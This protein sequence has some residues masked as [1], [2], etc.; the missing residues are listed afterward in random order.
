MAT[1]K[2]VITDGATLTD[3]GTPASD[4]K[5][6]IQD[7]SDSNTVKYVDWS[8]IGGGGGITDIVQDTTPQLGGNLDLNS[9]NV[10]GTGGIDI[11]GNIITSAGDLRMGTNNKFLQGK[12][13]GGA[14]R[15]IIGANASDQIVIGAAQYSGVTLTGVVTASSGIK[16]ILTSTSSISSAGDYGVGSEVYYYGST[17]T[18][19]G[20]IYYLD[21][22]GWTLADADAESTAK[23]LLGVAIGT[24]SGTNGMVIRGMVSLSVQGSPAVGAQV[25]LST[26]AGGA[27]S[28]APSATGD[29]QRILGH[30][31]GNGI[32]Y[33]NPSSDYLE[34][35]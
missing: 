17:T 35:A 32:V 28:V 5:L 3:I 30:V 7:T 9:S 1:W 20:Q 18:T 2:K 11:T 34:I 31:T 21:G 25:F 16:Q 14:T 8:D 29:I 33:F 24:N 19:A 4:D 13:S 22:T 26:T 15:P 6:L 12:T 27:S 23:G 10:T